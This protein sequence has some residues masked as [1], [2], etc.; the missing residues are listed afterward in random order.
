MDF[1]II[2]GDVY[3]S[4]KWNIDVFTRNIDTISINSFINNSPN[5]IFEDMFEIEK[6]L[7]HF[8]SNFKLKQ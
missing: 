3:N 4:S 2:N 7:K 6:Y 1:Y 5:K 8:K